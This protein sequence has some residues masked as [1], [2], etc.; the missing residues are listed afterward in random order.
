[1]K[2][3]NPDTGK[4]F[5]RG[6]T[7]D[8]DDLIFG[9]YKTQISKVT[10]YNYEMWRN[11]DQISNVLKKSSNWRKENREY[12][13]TWRKAANVTPEKRAKMLLRR[14]RTRAAKKQILFSL[15]LNDVLPAILQGKCQLTNLPFDLTQECNSWRNPYSPSIDRIDSSLGYVK[16][17]IR[18]VLT[19]VNITLNEFGESTMLP[20]L[21]EMVKAIEKNV[22]KK[23]ATPVSTGHHQQGEIY[24]EHGTVL[25]TRLGQDDDNA[26]HHCGADAR[27]DLDHRAQTSSRDSMGRGGQEVGTSL[28]SF[29]FQNYGVSCPA[30]E[31]FIRK[32]GHL[33]D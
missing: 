28:T 27:K 1:M 24:P 3:L 5:K 2:R 21:K 19:S 29:S 14:S 26:D 17:N 31:E 18:V 4:P 22:K 33:P 30:V 16:E 23:S 9:E 25:A 20:I 10:G 32:G 11:P 6:D 7:R 13:K 12:I 15:T 8:I